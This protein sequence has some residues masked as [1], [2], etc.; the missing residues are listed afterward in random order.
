LTSWTE[1]V[2]ANPWTYSSHKQGF[3]TTLLDKVVQ[4]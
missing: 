1:P 4:G 2:K 3:E